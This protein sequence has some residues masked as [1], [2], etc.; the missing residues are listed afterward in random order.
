M[1]HIR[2][3]VLIYVM[4][5]FLKCCLSA[6]DCSLPEATAAARFFL[7]PFRLKTFLMLL[8]GFDSDGGEELAVFGGVLTLD[9][10]V[11]AAAAAAVV[12][13]V[14]AAVAVCTRSLANISTLGREC[15]RPLRFVGLASFS[16]TVG[17]A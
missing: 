14:V 5:Y 6:S 16:D 17:R 11:D 7:L 2:S 13:A 3:W 4:S 1:K 12:V 8:K 10:G 9:V 15:G